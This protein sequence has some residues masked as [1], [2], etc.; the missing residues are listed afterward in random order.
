MGGRK[1]WG[2]GWGWRRRS[3]GICGKVPN[4]AGPFVEVVLCSEKAEIG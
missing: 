4:R 2:W 1:S 3:D